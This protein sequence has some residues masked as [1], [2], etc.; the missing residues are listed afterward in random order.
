[1]PYWREHSSI[2]CP[3]CQ[4]DG[5]MAPRSVSEQTDAIMRHLASAPSDLAVGSSV[6]PVTM[7][8]PTW[9]EPLPAEGAPDWRSPAPKVDSQPYQRV[10]S[11]A[12]YLQLGARGLDALRRLGPAAAA[13]LAAIIKSYQDQ[14][15]RP[16]SP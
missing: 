13:A 7:V 11:P 15:G 12:T 10:A 16:P 6:R 2:A 5:L 9:P 8:G 3:Q 4:G 1:M 14:L